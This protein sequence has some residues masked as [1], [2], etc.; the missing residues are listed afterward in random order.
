MYSPG[1]SC[2]FCISY[3]ILYCYLN[4]ILIDILI[5][6]NSNLQFS[7]NT[8]IGYIYLYVHIL[9]VNWEIIYKYFRKEFTI[10][11]EKYLHLKGTL[12][13]IFLTE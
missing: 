9:Y 4:T 2:K 7:A 1:S 10:G 6:L 13:S 12:T 3:L 8:I 5:A 11:G